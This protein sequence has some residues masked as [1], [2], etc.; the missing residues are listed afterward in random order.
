[1]SVKCKHSRAHRR[2]DT[3]RRTLPYTLTIQLIVGLGT[4]MS[5]DS[6]KQ[7]L[8]HCVV[9]ISPQ[10]AAVSCCEVMALGRLCVKLLWAQ[11]F[12]NHWKVDLPA[13]RHQTLA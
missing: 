10:S 6:A 12:S 7:N 4:N 1:M 2:H 8:L 9:S 3:P 5:V 11:A 13:L